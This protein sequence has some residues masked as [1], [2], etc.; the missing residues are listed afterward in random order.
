M[1][2]L[3]YIAAAL[4]AVF[5]GSFC[6]IFKFEKVAS[7][8]LDPFWFQLYVTCGVTLSCFLL[9][10]FLP[11]NP[12]IKQGYTDHFEFV[13]LAMA[14]GALFVLSVVSFLYIYHR[15]STSLLL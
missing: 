15:W 4:S 13:P 7:L 1:S 9:C 11:L 3:G 10:A 8:N 5:N 14:A 12:H 6:A 2:G